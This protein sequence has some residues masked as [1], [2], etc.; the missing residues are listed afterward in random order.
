MG[1]HECGHYKPGEIVS[2]SRLAEVLR[3]IELSDGRIMTVFLYHYDAPWNEGSF[4]SSAL[5]ITSA[6]FWRP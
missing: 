1:P 5:G 4:G 2:L 3:T 6:V